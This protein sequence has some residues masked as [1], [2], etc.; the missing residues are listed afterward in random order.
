MIPKYGFIIDKIDI[1]DCIKIKTFAPCNT[2]LKDEKASDRL[3]KILANHN[4]DKGLIPR[5]C[6]ELSKNDIKNTKIQL[7]NEKR[8][9]ETFH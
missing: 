2:L 9:K 8:H 7:E 3:G 1:L 5:I 4:S 6:Q